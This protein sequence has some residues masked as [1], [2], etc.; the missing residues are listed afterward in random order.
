[1]ANKHTCRSYATK[2]IREWCR[3]Q[4]QS[5][6]GILRVMA[7]NEKDLPWKDT[8]QPEGFEED[9]VMRSVSPPVC[10]VYIRIHVLPPLTAVCGLDGWI[11]SIGIRRVWS[12]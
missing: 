9:V 5:L 10:I 12:N 1:M 8:P 6:P 7:T 2:R 11:C 3:T 4:F